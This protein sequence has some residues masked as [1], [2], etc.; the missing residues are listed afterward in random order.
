VTNN[1]NTIGTM[2]FVSSVQNDESMTDETTPSFDRSLLFSSLEDKKDHPVVKDSSSS[3]RRHEELLFSAL[4]DD[5]AADVDS[6]DGDEEEDEHQDSAEI[7][8]MFVNIKESSLGMLKA[9]Y[10]T[11]HGKKIESDSF[12]SLVGFRSGR[13]RLWTAVFVCPLTGQKYPS[14][15]VRKTS[16]PVLINSKAI[17]IKEGEG[18]AFYVRK[19]QAIHAAAARA[20]DV[21]QYKK[22]GLL[23]PRFCD[24]FPSLP[25]ETFGKAKMLSDAEILMEN[26]GGLADVTSSIFDKV[27]SIKE[28]YN[29]RL[30]LELEGSFESNRSMQDG[31]SKW[32]TTFDCPILGKTF[33]AGKLRGSYSPLEGDIDNENDQVY[34]RKKALSMHAAIARA[35]DVLQFSRHGVLEPRFCEEDPSKDTAVDAQNSGTT[36]TG[37]SGDDDDGE[38]CQSHSYNWFQPAEGS[39]DGAMVRSFGPDAGEVTEILNE[40][41]ASA[42]DCAD[43]FQVVQ[44]GPPTTRSPM[45]RLLELACSNTTSSSFTNNSLSPTIAPDISRKRSVAGIE[46]VK[47]V[48]A[49]ADSWLTHMSQSSETK[50]NVHRL[51]LRK[52]QGSVSMLLVA[53]AILAKLAD[54]NQSWPVESVS[55][56]ESRAQ[57]VIDLLL[58]TTDF[59]PD[60]DT[61]TLYLKCLSAADPKAG[62]EEAE[63]LVAAMKKG[64]FYEGTTFV[65]PQPNHATINALIQLTA[66]TGGTSGR[67]AKYTDDGFVPDRESFLSVLSS[68]NYRPANELESG[69]FDPEFAKECIQRMSELAHATGDPTLQPDTQVYNAPL[70][71]SG[72]PALWMESRP[73]ARYIPWKKYEV[74]YANGLRDVVDSSDIRICQAKESEAWLDTMI[75]MNID[76]DI[77]S[78]EAVIQA[79]LLTATLEGLERAEALLD[80]LLSPSST[81]RPRLETFHPVIAAWYHS[82]HAESIAKTLQ[83]NERVEEVDADLA[84]RMKSDPRIIE[85]QLMAH[86]A[87]QRRLMDE[88]KTNKELVSDVLNAAIKSSEILEET[89][90]QLERGAFHR[91]GRGLFL[92]ICLFDHVG[93]A[94]RNVSAAC[95]KSGDKAC[96]DQA[97]SEVV[98]TFT[99]FDS[100]VQTLIEAEAPK[101]KGVLLGSRSHNLSRQLGHVVASAHQFFFVVLE[102][103]VSLEEQ[104]PRESSQFSDQDFRPLLMLEK[105]TR[106]VG[107][108]ERIESHF[109]ESDPDISSRKDD[110]WGDWSELDGLVSFEDQF[111][112]GCKDEN[113]FSPTRYSL[114]W[115][116]VKYLEDKSLDGANVGDVARLGVLIKEVGKLLRNSPKMEEAVDK[117][118]D[119]VLP[120]APQ[121]AISHDVM[122]RK[123]SEDIK[124]RSV[125]R[126]TTKTPRKRQHQSHASKA[127][128]I[129]STI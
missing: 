101:P 83:W 43:D 45:H 89:C 17:Q 51:E 61:F 106:M 23:E 40:S 52:Q 39:T 71:W 116:A 4:E 128:K 117:L 88:V 72:G 124:R 24:D 118:L 126:R 1:I 81:I 21:I 55:G 114:L 102:A 49:S 32:T 54:A 41:D 80:K 120:G 91:N 6:D 92:D 22:K 67:Y 79:W 85:V 56:V 36:T 37:I 48:I 98:C 82:K 97:I 16:R 11:E 99:T 19:N 27:G 100:M 109:K 122:A 8:P 93:Q 111:S 13:K 9:H 50:R 28:Y 25:V 59:R 70:R 125:A 112:Y 20:L 65:L 75:E 42:E 14:G 31:V 107:E 105:M 104:R 58:K 119:R 46:Q 69:G 35:Y 30:G 62:L 53:K 29:K 77:E 87:E 26:N 108:F 34:Y 127:K 2:R 38:T 66:Q 63:K 5:A 103:L 129:S 12:E 123:G 47:A 3:S 68:C 10:S 73:Y 64:D 57:R 84:D 15:R 60:A 110:I 44:I 115:Q 96:L 86:L 95:L 7:P 18:P 78:Y 113:R 94:W 74:V 76:P 33:K 121:R 90:G